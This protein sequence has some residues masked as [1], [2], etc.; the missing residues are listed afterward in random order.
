MLVFNWFT[1]YPLRFNR[2]AFPAMAGGSEFRA[3]HTRNARYTCSM[4]S[5]GGESSA[6]HGR[7]R[8]PRFGKK[9]EGLLEGLCSSRSTNQSQ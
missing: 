1:S 3:F 6:S 8:M 4:N 9:K 2:V 5:R 7:E